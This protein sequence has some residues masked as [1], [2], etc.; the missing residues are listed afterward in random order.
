MT[1]MEV[2]YDHLADKRHSAAIGNPLRNAAVDLSLL[3]MAKPAAPA[4]GERQSTT[5]EAGTAGQPGRARRFIPR[6][7]SEPGA[8]RL[9]LSPGDRAGRPVVQTEHEPPGEGAD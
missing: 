4:T 6:S 2:G 3:R 5:V 9:H 8:G 7:R 1:V